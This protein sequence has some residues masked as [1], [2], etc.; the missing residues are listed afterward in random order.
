M[1]GSSPPLSPTHTAGGPRRRTRGP[2]GSLALR[3]Q[4]RA[5]LVLHP[6]IEEFRTSAN[7][8]IGV[9]STKRVGN[10][11][12]SWCTKR[13][14]PWEIHH[15]AVCR[16]EG[17]LFV[18]E[19]AMF[20]GR[21]LFMSLREEGSLGLPCR[22]DREIMADLVPVH[23]DERRTLAVDGGHRWSD[24]QATGVVHKE[25]THWS[26]QPWC[27]FVSGFAGN[28]TISTNRSKGVR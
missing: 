26:L 10:R 25:H 20:R 16:S 15:R 1:V 8:P 3:R 18:N 5:P 2:W 9:N 22:R 6:R 13:R 24:R 11:F 14:T 21:A 23:P 4:D 27:S 19:V 17:W 28:S 7:I 12:A